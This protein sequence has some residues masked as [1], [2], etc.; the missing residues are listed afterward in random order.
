MT[1]TNEAVQVGH[2][3]NGKNSSFCSGAVALTIISEMASGDA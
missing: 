3:I 1:L 2:I